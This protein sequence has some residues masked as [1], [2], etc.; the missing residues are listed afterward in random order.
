[1]IDLSP[2]TKAVELVIDK[3]NRAWGNRGAVTITRELVE[4]GF[5]I[6][7][8]V[9]IEHWHYQPEIDAWTAYGYSTLFPVRVPEGTP[10]VHYSLQVDEHGR[11]TAA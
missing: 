7:L 8:H 5:D 1:M 9:S 10:C 3:C 11:A 6:R 4:E 2:I